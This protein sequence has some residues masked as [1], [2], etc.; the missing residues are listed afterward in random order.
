VLRK[1]NCAVVLATQSLSD[2]VKS[3]LLDVL[4]EACATKMLLP[5]EEADKEGTEQFPG[6]RDYYALFGLNNVQIDIVKTAIKKRQYYYMS[7]DGRR[8]FDLGLGPMAL[9]F[10]AVSSKEDVARVCELEAEHGKAWPY[11]WLE[12]REVD[13]VAL[14]QHAA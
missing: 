13:Y 6:P 12:E 10:C 14:Q 1:A 7:A 4:I 11:R 3:G 9:A 8:L 5:N 2:A